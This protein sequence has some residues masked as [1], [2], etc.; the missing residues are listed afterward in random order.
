MRYF[1]VILIE[2]VNTSIFSI[3][4]V[5]FLA[6]LP[7]RT[8]FLILLLAAKS[9]PIFVFIGSV[10]AFLIQ[11]S[12]SVLFGGLLGK[13]P[14]Q[15]VSLGS[16]ILFVFFSFKMWRERNEALEDDGYA[17][18]SHSG[19]SWIGIKDSFLSVFIAEWGDVSQ[20]AIASFAAQNPQ[21]LTV[22]FGAS[23]ALSLTA[24]LAVVVGSHSSKVF[25]PKQIHVFSM[26]VFAGVGACFLLK[27]FGFF[28]IR[29]S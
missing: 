24:A 13:L 11:A 7:G 4:S 6:A 22:W 16:G 23:V 17:L 5:L 18:M 15:W 28:W 29:A 26:L 1:N 3:I 25:Q 12:I 20:L 19:S 9:R 21:P 2:G 8:T 27:G 14:A 10:F